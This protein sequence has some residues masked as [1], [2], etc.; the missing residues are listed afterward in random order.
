MELRVAGIVRESVV[1]GPGIRSVVFAQGC[2]RHCRGCHNPEAIDPTGGKVLE[3]REILDAIGKT[4]LIRG[5]TFS[6]GE[7]FMQAEAF[8]ELGQRLKEK[9]L[10]IMTYTGYTWEELLNMGRQSPAVMNL[11]GITDY[12]VDGPFMEEE[13]DLNLAF[14][15]SRNQ[16]V[17]DVQRSIR[18]RDVILAGLTG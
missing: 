12:L 6:G 17:I 5:V 16:R 1:D 18:E 7:P 9:G 8:A 3:D 2:P 14:R 13:K 15:G 4:R 10:D 11:L